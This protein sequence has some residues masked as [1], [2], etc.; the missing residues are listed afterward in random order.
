MVSY[1]LMLVCMLLKKG[2]NPYCN[3]R[4]SRT[5]NAWHSCKQGGSVLILIVME[6]GLVRCHISVLHGF[7]IGLNPYC[8]GRWSRTSL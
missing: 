5:P 6:D 3:G 7:N 4:W 1:L 2:L 8:N